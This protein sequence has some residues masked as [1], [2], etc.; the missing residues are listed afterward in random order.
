MSE[1]GSKIKLTVFLIKDGY[2]S[3]DD[4]I[5][6]KGYKTL[7]IQGD[8][9]ELGTLFYKGGF[10]SVPAWAEI[11]SD[12]DG[13]DKAEIYSQSSRALHVIKVEGR[14]FC[15]SFGHGRHLINQ[16]AYERNFGLIVS[17][18]LSDPESIRSIDKV[19]LAGIS[20]HSRSQATKDIEFG[21]FDFD[22]DIN[23]LKSITAKIEK[24][25]KNDESGTVSGK[26]SVTIYTRVDVGS[27]Y[28]IANQLY[29]AYKDERYKDL[30]PWVEYV[31]EERDKG[32]I[33]VLDRELVRLIDDKQY[34]KVWLA[35]P[36]VIDWTDVK[37]F[38]YKKAQQGPRSHGPLLS[39][40]I[41]LSDW[42]RMVRFRG[43]LSADKLKVKQVFLYWED[44]R[45]PTGYKI[46]RC[47]N[48]E[49]DYEG[50]KYILNDGDWYNIESNYVNEINAFYNSIP[51]SLIDLPQYAGMTEPDYLKHVALVDEGYILM[52]RKTISIGG[53]RSRVEFCDLFS[54]GKDIIHVKKYG[55]SSVLSHLFQQGLVSGECFLRE[56]EFRKKVNDLLPDALKLADFNASPNPGEYT[57]CLA[58]MSDVSGPLELPFFSKISLK[59]AVKSLQ[60]LGYR[61]AKLKIER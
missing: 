6:A 9:G 41:D 19:S 12:V 53:G 43:P 32:V 17:L 10:K 27:F 24:T 28:K 50:K 59:Y 31:K 5:D 20:L 7:D 40:D 47:L 3:F 13:F 44:G 61:V 21:A 52:D 30:Y 57:V 23:I 55:G 33:E 42:Q 26:D 14:F 39:L 16:L 18:N 56:P 46:Y 38:A 35:V 15:F 45:P 54:A 48:A 36:E 51:N 49:V 22:Y 11:F 34:N 25:E 58:I 8:D 1:E 60:N 37:G 2:E 29:S 4:F